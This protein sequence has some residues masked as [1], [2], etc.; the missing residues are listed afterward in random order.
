MSESS[1]GPK[2]ETGDVVVL[3][4]GDVRMT[5]SYVG[6]GDNILCTWHDANKTLQQAGFK[7]GV[8]QRAKS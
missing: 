2:F 5:V 1:T 3:K 6:P 8:L 7:I 4:G